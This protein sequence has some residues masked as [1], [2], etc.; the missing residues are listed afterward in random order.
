MNEKKR[1]YVWRHP[2]KNK[3]RLCKGLQAANRVS[4]KALAIERI[5]HVLEDKDNGNNTD[6]LFEETAEEDVIMSNGDAED[7]G[8]DDTE[9]DE[10]DLFVHQN[11]SAPP[12]T[13]RQ[14][15]ILVRK[16]MDEL[17]DLATL[18]LSKPET[19]RGYEYPLRQALDK[20]RLGETGDISAGKRIFITI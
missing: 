7:E 12:A 14:L 10:D 15:T 5:S 20:V 9:D 19:I 3:G 6:G 8:Q 16:N 2:H 11:R 17:Y 4:V 18:N 1:P 13:T